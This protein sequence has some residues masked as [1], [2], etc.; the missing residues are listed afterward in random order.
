M[1]FG[2]AL[3]VLLHKYSQT[4]RRSLRKAAGEDFQKQL[5]NEEVRIYEHLQERSLTVKPL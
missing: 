3:P 2:T 5:R 1:A 4:Q